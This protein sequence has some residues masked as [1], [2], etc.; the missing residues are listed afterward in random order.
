MIVETDPDLRRLLQENRVI[1]MVGL[2]ANVTRPSHVVARY[3]MAHG[4]TVIPV[5]P[6]ELEILGQPCYARLADIPVKVDVVDC[7][8]KSADILPIAREAIDIGA[9]VLWMQQEV[10]NPEAARM[11]V[12]AGLE[13]VMDRCIKID[14]ARLL[15]A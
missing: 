15:G 5:N 4:Y 8:R 2:S 1:A 3:L 7:F 9:R 12:E 14:H 10:I 13:V 6:V 11:A